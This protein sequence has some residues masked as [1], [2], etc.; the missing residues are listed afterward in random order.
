MN[1]RNAIAA[2]IAVG[3]FG[4]VSYDG[5]YSPGCVAYAGSNIRLSDGQFVWEKFTDSVVVDD[6]GNAVNQYPGYPLQGSYRVEGQMLYLEAA[7]SEAMTN[8]YFQLHDGRHYLLTAEEL[9]A[10]EISGSFPE[11]PLVLGGN[12]DKR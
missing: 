11:C 9:D 2:L 4:C 6:A 12:T 8:M 10:F 7:S 3:L 5:A 1:P